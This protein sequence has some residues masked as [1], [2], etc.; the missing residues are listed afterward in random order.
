MSS[1]APARL[2]DPERVPSRLG[3]IVFASKIWVLRAQRGWRNLLSPVPRHRAHAEAS[4]PVQIAEARIPLWTTESMVERSLQLG[5]VQNLRIAVRALDGIVVPAGE[6]FSFWRQLGRAT[7]RRGYVSGREL[8]EGCLIPAIGGGLCQLSNALYDAALQSGC[9]IVERHAHSRI[10]PGSAAEAGRDATVAWNYVDLRFRPQPDIRMR[11]QLS[12]E[13]LSVRFLAAQ[14]FAHGGTISTDATPAASP[15]ILPRV[16]NPIAHTCTDCGVSDCFRHLE[17]Q[18]PSSSKTAY[19]LDECWPEFLAYVDEHVSTD[20]FVTVPAI[21]GRYRNVRRLSAKASLHSTLIPALWRA[22]R[23]RAASTVPRRVQA[24]L[25]GSEHVAQALAR[26]IPFD[27]T[28]VVV[29]QSLVPFLW[30]AGALGGRTFDVLM[31]RTPLAR[32]HSL[33]D[34]A[35]MR[36]PEQKTLREYRAPEEMIHAEQEA[37]AAARRV[38]TPHAAI[39]ALFGERA[40]RLPWSIPK[41]ARAQR[42]RTAI[43]PGPTVARKG[44]LALHAALVALDCDLMILARNLEQADFWQGVRIVPPAENWLEDAA[45]VVQPAL[46]EDN[47]RPLLRAVAAGIPVICTS[48]CGLGDLPGVTTVEFGNVEQLRTALT[49]ALRSCD[50]CGSP[51]S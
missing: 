23:M 5:K 26:D 19:L 9:E 16:L 15:G 28:H 47:P 4:L 36:N 42:G 30:K 46:L 32:L 11:V 31:T 45:V 14:P 34:D 41:V 29:A 48:N 12:A 27:V 44:A 18:A 2:P 35:S 50:A 33:L 37:L 1:P 8:R 13:Q 17:A 38:I 25:S 7:H 49:A 51:S 43:F 39:A 10:V 40:I 3:A 20:D 6:I 21:F 24:Q 22:I